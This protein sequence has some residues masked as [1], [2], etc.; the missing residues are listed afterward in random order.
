MIAPFGHPFYIMAK[1]VGSSCNL[2]CNYCY[3][4]SKEKGVMSDDLLETFIQQNIEAQTQENILFTWHGGE[5][6]LRPISFYKHAL[7]LQQKYARGRHI[8]NCLQT[9]GTLIT[10]E[11][12]EFFRQNNFLI[13]ISIDGP[14]WMHNHY[15]QQFDKT[16]QGIQL[17]KR[18]GVQWNVMATV[19]HLNADHPQ[20]FYHFFRELLPIHHSFR[21]QREGRHDS[22]I[23]FP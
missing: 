15:R 22:D 10:D 2:N 9:N 17:L 1:P 3:Y 19:N 14:E 8:D 7:E 5:P 6:L 12:C 4:L 16:L 11:W 23:V 13:G 20:E 21:I 18:H